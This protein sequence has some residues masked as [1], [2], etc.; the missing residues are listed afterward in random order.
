MEDE[1]LL[2]AEERRMLERKCMRVVLA[3][4][5]VIGKIIGPRTRMLQMIGQYG[6]VESYCH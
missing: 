3:K 5:Y 6:V 1:D 4:L 2:T